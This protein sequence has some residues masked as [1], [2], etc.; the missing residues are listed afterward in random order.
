MLSDS[1]EDKLNPL[2]NQTSSWLHSFTEKTTSIDNYLFDSVVN[3]VSSSL[4][5]WL[6][7]HPLVAWLIH[8]PLITLIVSFVVS[9]LLIRLLVTIYQ[10]IANMIDRL[11]LWILRSPWILLKLLFG[12]SAKPVST[13]TTITNYEVTHNPEQL[14][15]I[16]IR[17]DKIQQQQS[18]IIQDLAQLK[19]QPRTIEVQKLRL[20]EKK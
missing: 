10:A 16:M 13:D 3:S 20:I 9:V 19:Q 12:W 1:L 11:W 14:Q 18:Q 2:K 6:I 5:N 7:Q 4:N 8:H 17:L 15:E